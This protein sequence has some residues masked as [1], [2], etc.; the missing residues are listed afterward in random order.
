MQIQAVAAPAP[1]WIYDLAFPVGVT[2]QQQTS[3]PTYTT[4][5]RILGAANVNNATPYLSIY[6]E[7]GTGG[8]FPRKNG[9]WE[10]YQTGGTNGIWINFGW[11]NPQLS[12]QADRLGAWIP[13]ESVVMVLDIV[14]AWDGNSGGATP[15]N[16]VPDANGFYFVPSWNSTGGTSYVES[17]YPGGTYDE[18]GWG[19]VINAGPPV[20]YEFISWIPGTNLMRVPDPNAVDVTQSHHI[21][22]TVVTG[23]GSTPGYLSLTMDGVAWVTK[24]AFDNV[25]LYD[26]D[27]IAA[28]P[29]N[30]YSA[31]NMS[32]AN[33]VQSTAANNVGKRYSWRARFGPNL[34]DGEVIQAGR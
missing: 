20:H 3:D 8:T 33:V 19:I 16:L 30:I 15:L 4:A 14:A 11:W 29:V 31:L 5:T 9:R 17:M 18:G 26:L 21:Q 24:Q 1:L 28:V 23:Y 13:P 32:L 25:S 7:G 27:G 12:A 22:L 6:A 10:H 2:G 34:P